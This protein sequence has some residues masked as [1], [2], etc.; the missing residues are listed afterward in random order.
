[1]L[2]GQNSC[3]SDASLHLHRIKDVA[4]GAMM[5]LCGHRSPLQ[6]AAQHQHQCAEHGA[7]ERGK[8]W[9]VT[10]KKNTPHHNDLV[11][12]FKVRSLKR[13]KITK[14]VVKSSNNT[15]KTK[16]VTMITQ[17]KIVPVSFLSRS[18][19]FS[20]SKL[21]LSLSM[22]IPLFLYQPFTINRTLEIFRFEKQPPTVI[23]I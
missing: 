2:L 14:Q 20:V 23:Y 10:H 18:G 15:S 5:P 11:R 8:M 6:Q 4:I 7:L 9:S 3:P 12:F 21:I 22:G 13:Q 19:L 17:I 16:Y 1:M